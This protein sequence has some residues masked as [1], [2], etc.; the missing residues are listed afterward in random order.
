MKQMLKVLYLSKHYSNN[1]NEIFLKKNPFPFLL[2]EDISYIA[3]IPK[4]IEGKFSVHICLQDL[5]AV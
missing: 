1:Y 2:L 5:A 4:R 3:S